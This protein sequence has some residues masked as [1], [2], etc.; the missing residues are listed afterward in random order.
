[1]N[2]KLQLHGTE[3]VARRWQAL[4]ERRR[5]HLT[6]LHDSGRW[7]KYYREHNF[8]T[9]L[10]ETARISDAWDKVLAGASARA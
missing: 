6:D 2:K 10:R 7:R 4:A 9:Q 5:E 3:D 1:M 8:F